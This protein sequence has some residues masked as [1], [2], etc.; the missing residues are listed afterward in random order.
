M[1]VP[2]A[3]VRIA[4]AGGTM[5]AAGRLWGRRRK[6]PDPGHA[7]TRRDISHQQAGRRAPIRAKAYCLP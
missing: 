5:T 6:R 2:V 1:F 4:R 7:R 3:G